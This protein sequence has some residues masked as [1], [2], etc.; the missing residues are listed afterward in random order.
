M[1]DSI[2][3]LDEAVIPVTVDYL[4]EDGVY[5]VSCPLLQGCHAWGKTL[6]DAM[7]AMPENVRAMTAARL[8][9]GSP[10]P[11]SL[12][13]LRDHTRLVIRMVPA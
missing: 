13:H 6:D 3:E 5:K 2:I 1:M 12:E 9:N 8:A 7:R 11:A 4:E 10:I